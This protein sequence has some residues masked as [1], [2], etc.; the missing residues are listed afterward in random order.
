METAE[1]LETISRGEDTRHQFKADATNANGLGAEIAV[2]ANASGGQIFIGVADDG[3]MQGLGAPDVARINQLVANA[4][5]NCIRPPINPV[6]ENVPVAGGVVIVLSIPEGLSKPYTDNAGVI[7]VKSGAEKR[8]VTAR[9][10]MQR[11]F[12][13]SQL[14]HGDDIPVAGTSVADIDLENFRRFFR[15]RFE[16]ELDEQNLSLAQ[17]L[18][19]MRLLSDERLT[20]TGILLFARDSATLLPAF[21]IKAVSYPGTDIHAT[22]YLESADI[23]GRIDVQFEG[24]MSFVLR[25]LRREQM[26][27]GVNSLGELE[28]PRIALEELL[29]NALIHRDYFVSAPIRIFV[30]DDHSGGANNNTR[31]FTGTCGFKITP[32]GTLTMLH[33]FDLTDG[34]NPEEGLIQ[35]SDGNFYGTTSGTIFKITP[36]G[37][38]TTLYIWDNTVGGYGAGPNKLVQDTSGTFYGTTLHG[39]NGIYHYCGGTCG[40]I[41][42]LSVGLGP[43]VE[44]QPGSGMVGAAIKILGTNLTGASSV[45]FNGTAAKF[46]V[47]SSSEITTTVPAGATTGEVKVVTP[48]GTLSS[49]VSFMVP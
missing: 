41:F 36:T 47:I 37:T 31:C 6:T 7:W 35:A 10:E 32:A 40:T 4:A 16:Q 48:S 17:V 14:I 49:N 29:A 46:T 39:G 38:L 30:F 12:Q 20:V 15:S 13:S 5:S 34:Y 3:T 2:F 9:E 44:A 26:S 24:A 45:S 28:I 22:S 23:T 25:H 43:F 1:L 27:Q 11:M 8:R 19:N 33:S 18:T 21:H 42:S